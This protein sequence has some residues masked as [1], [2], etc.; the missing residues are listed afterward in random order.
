VTT[1]AANQNPLKKHAQERE[2]YGSL[3]IGHYGTGFGIGIG[4]TIAAIGITIA[5]TIAITS[6][7]GCFCCCF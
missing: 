4:T 5:I 2:W 3:L 7:R 6:S 1:D